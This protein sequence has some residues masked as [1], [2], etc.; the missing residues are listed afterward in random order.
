[1][2]NQIESITKEINFPQLALV[3]GS[4]DIS[5][6]IELGKYLGIN[7]CS[8]EP[9]DS[10]NNFKHEIPAQISRPGFEKV[11]HLAII[12]DK[13]SGSIE[14]AFKSI[15]NIFTEKTNITELPKQHGQ[16][17]DGGLKIGIFIMPGKL[18]GTMLEDLC[19]STMA[20]NPIMKCVE[21]FADCI[22]E[23]PETSTKIAK[24]KALAYL[25]AQKEPVNTIGLGAQKGYWN[26]EAPELDELKEFL[27]ELKDN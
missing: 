27:L 8:A 25:A 5:F 14:D 24:T 18:N 11:T 3:E 7:S 4:D 13:D 22:K 10:V 15:R 16:W 12:R 21:E 9:V 1:M 6:F 2:D 23:K 17:S 26:F 20:D 19:L